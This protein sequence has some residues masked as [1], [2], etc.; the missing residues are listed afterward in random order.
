M[1]KA[2]RVHQSQSV[3]MGTLRFALCPSCLKIRL[4]WNPGLEN[5]PI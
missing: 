5:W 2:Q 4:G 1:G 3:P